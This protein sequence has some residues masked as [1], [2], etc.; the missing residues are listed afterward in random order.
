MKENA[1]IFRQLMSLAFLDI[2]VR[3]GIRRIT[4]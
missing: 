1:A 4:R 3:A 2:V